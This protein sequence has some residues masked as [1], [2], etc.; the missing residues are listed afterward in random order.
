MGFQIVEIDG[1]SFTADGRLK[2]AQEP[3]V[4]PPAT[5][6]VDVGGI[7]TVGSGGGGISDVI[8]V[9]ATGQTLVV[10]NY[11]GGAA[12]KGE[13]SKVELFYDPNGNGTGMTLVRAAYVDG[14]SFSIDLNREFGPGNGTRA[15]RLRRSN[16]GGASREIAAFVAG[17]ERT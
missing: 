10:Q 15:I 16:L 14:E 6:P 12:R 13:G 1:A 11:N 2:V 7:A 9:I 4:P 3:P 8:Y 5:T 17:Y